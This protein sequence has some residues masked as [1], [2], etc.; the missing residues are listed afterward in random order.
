MAGTVAEVLSRSKGN[1][2]LETSRF[3]QAVYVACALRKKKMPEPCRPHPGYQA[4]VSYFLHELIEEHNPRS[5][6][7]RVHASDIN[8]LFSM[9]GFPHPADFNDK[10]NMSARLFQ[11]LKEEEDVARQRDPTTTQTFA[12]MAMLPVLL[13]YQDHRPEEG[14]V[15]PKGA[16]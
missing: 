4:I 7:V 10:Q 11:A 12:T 16:D 2:G 1:S 3:R 8:D 13:P 5:A 9:R 15:R 14:R 6:T